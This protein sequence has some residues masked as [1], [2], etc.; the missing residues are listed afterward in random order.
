MTDP[1]RIGLIYPEL[2]GTYGDRGNAVVLERRLAWRGLAGEVVTIPAGE[3]VPGG[4]DLYVLGGAEDVPQTL[5]AEGLL[6]SK[7]AIGGAL[8]GGAAMLAVCA[9]FQLIGSSYV[10]TDGAR[11]PG[12][13]LVDADTVAGPRRRIGEVVIDPFPGG[14][15][16]LTGFENH[17]GVTTLGPGARPLGAVLVGTGN[18]DGQDGAWVERRFVATYLHGPVLARNAALA[19]L[20]LTWVA[21]PLPA[22]RDGSG[23]ALVEKL[24]AERLAAAGVGRSGRR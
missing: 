16:L 6:A 11:V 3:P 17:A 23:D 21:G 13:G 15:P 1:V 2:M 22:L 24:H 9:G 19:D 7:A 4:L 5:A 20:L 18:G 8:D 12:M 14:L 10:R